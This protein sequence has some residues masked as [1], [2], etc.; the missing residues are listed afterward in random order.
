MFRTDSSEEDLAGD[1]RRQ[2]KVAEEGDLC[3][4]QSWADQVEKL[5]PEN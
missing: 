5:N 2:S 3:S 4:S 1:G